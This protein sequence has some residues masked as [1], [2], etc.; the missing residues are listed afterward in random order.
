MASITTSGCGS[1]WT[2]PASR[3]SQTSLPSRDQD[4]LARD[5][6]FLLVTKG[7]DGVVQ[8]V[9]HGVHRAELAALDGRDD[10][11]EHLLVRLR[12]LDHPSAPLDT[13]DAA[14][15]EQDLIRRQ[16]RD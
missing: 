3:R 1:H 2:Y 11:V 12:V 4:G 13:R 9:L 7:G 5:A 6:A 8:P 15:A 14:V 10:V 16:P